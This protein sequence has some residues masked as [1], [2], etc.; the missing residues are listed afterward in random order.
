MEKNDNVF[1]NGNWQDYN[2]NKLNWEAILY[3]VRVTWVKCKK[4]IKQSLNEEEK[5]Y[6]DLIKVKGGTI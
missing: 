3:Y 2:V 4:I 6:V 1:N 5:H